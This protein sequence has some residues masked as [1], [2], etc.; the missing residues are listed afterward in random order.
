MNAAP[1]F[2]CDE[3]LSQLCHYLRAAGYDTLLAQNGASDGELLQLCQAEGRHF[4]TQDKLI[5]EH[6]A[7]HNVA[8]ILPHANLNH[9]AT[10]LTE[11]YQLDWLSQSFTRCLM[12]NT[13]LVAADDAA[14][15]RA[16]ADT[17]NSGERLYH[18]PACSR[19]YWR[20]SHYKRIRT[21]LAAWQA[22]GK[23]PSAQSSMET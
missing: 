11:H 9:L 6:K 8:L 21:K 10:L 5:C 15:A 12:D 23:N 4:L 7:A 1:R 3:M 14:L 2:L 16:P 13:P 22:A 20:G 17:L 18:C 19:V